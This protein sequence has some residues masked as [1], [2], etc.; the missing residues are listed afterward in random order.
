MSKYLEMKTSVSLTR[1]P[2]FA[3]VVLREAIKLAVVRGTFMVRGV[4]AFVLK[5]TKPRLHYS[6]VSGKKV[7]IPSYNRVKFVASRSLNSEINK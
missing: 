4:G 1:N 6:G 5:K 2:E 7:R 3:A